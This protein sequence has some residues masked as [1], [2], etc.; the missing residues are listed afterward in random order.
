MPSDSFVFQQDLKQQL[1]A[2]RDSIHQTHATRLHRALSWLKASAEQDNN[3][4]MQLI[5]LWVSFN[6]CYAKGAVKA[7][8]SILPFNA[9]LKSW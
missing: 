4:D 9:W 8:P 2:C 7:W 3:L 1:R 6:A 5:S